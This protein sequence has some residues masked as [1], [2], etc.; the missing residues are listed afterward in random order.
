M[1]ILGDGARTTEIRGIPDNGD[2]LESRATVSST[3]SGNPVTIGGL[4]LRNG[5]ANG[6][7]TNGDT[8]GDVLQ[9]A[10]TSR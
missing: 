9:P 10:A 2:P 7:S 5:R 6:E 1:T 8:G 3:S 4:T